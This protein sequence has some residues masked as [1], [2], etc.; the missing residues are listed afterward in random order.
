MV[1]DELVAMLRYEIR[2]EQNARKF[3]QGIDSAERSARSFSQ[4]MLA[5]GGVIG[6]ALAGLAITDKIAGFVGSITETGSAF[7]NMGVRLKALE[8]S[9][10]GAEKA[11]AWI[12]DFAKKTP[13]E[14]SEVVDAYANLRTYGI[15]PTNGSMQAVTD[16]MAA[17]G[18]G[19]EKLNGIIMGLGQAWTKQKL[20]GEEIM[21]LLERGIPVW[22]MLAT[23][24][25]KS[26]PELQ[27][28]SSAGKLGRKEI[29]L[30][31]DMIGKRYKGAS[32][33]FS[34]TFDGITSNLKDNWTQF[35]KEIADAGYYDSV[36]YR[37][38]G[39]LDWV[40][41]QWENGLAHG[42]ATRISDFLV[43]SMRQIE[44]IAT[45][46]W[47]IGRGFYAAADG[48]VA[49]T[50]KITGLSK[51]WAAAGLGVGLL[52]SRAGG[53]AMM[54]AMARRVPMLAAALAID[55]L[56]GALNGDDSV[57]G[58]T[59]KG[60]KAIENLKTQFE[61][62]RTTL[63]GIAS[64]LDK[65]RE[66]IAKSFDLPPD[67][68]SSI[69]DLSKRWDELRD[70]LSFEIKVGKLDIDPIK[71]AFDTVRQWVE[72]AASDFKMLFTDPTQFAVEAMINAIDLVAAKF[73][74]IARNLGLLQQYAGSIA[75]AMGAPGVQS[76]D[77]AP[78]K[79]ALIGS[80]ASP[81]SSSD[82]NLSMRFGN[83]DFLGAANQAQKAL[84]DLARPVEGKAD[85]NIEPFL[86]K[87]RAAKAAAA[88]LSSIT[89]GG[90][91]GRVVSRPSVAAGPAAP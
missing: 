76:G 25:G 88:E 45:Q 22:D 49:L 19:A 20:Q 21:Q 85:L 16:A 61:S 53:R 62:L 12:T 42:V 1:V 63:Q 57:V 14:L 59:P 40:N 65:A 24:T 33:D 2:G 60:Q 9:S 31:I 6:G 70:S 5:L 51:G 87:V 82:G 47:R 90:K 73:E 17:T 89:A 55:D 80:L 83:A 77:A 11:L 7:E 78:Q 46:A 74:L 39:L 43:V 71:V 37:L 67:T 3:K 10:E 38:Q 35:L 69:T 54:M 13:L 29:G 4:T 23:A 79:G 75:Q 34:K 50:A 36:K 48:V 91:G 15:D 86:A 64:D 56:I 84:N 58:S 41:R 52:A 18:G 30:L 44:H 27:K 72:K 32:E 28:L 81:P 68:L 26:V 8:G 66:R